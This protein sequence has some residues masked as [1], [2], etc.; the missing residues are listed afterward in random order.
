MKKIVLPFILLLCVFPFMQSYAN[1]ESPYFSAIGMDYDSLM[2]ILKDKEVSFDRKSEL[3]TEIDLVHPLSKVTE[4]YAALLLQA[5]Q[6]ED[7]TMTVK[8]YSSIANNMLMEQD[9]ETAKVYLD[10]AY[11]YEREA[12][13]I[14]SLAMLNFMMGRYYQAVKQEDKAHEYIYKTIDAYEGLAGKR[15]VAIILLYSMADAYYKYSDT[16]SLKKTLDRMIPLT[17]EVNQTPYYVMTYSVAYTYYGLMYDKG[18]EHNARF[19]DSVMVYNKKISDIYAEAD[20]DNKLSV[21]SMVIQSYLNTAEILSR[22]ENPDWKKINQYVEEAGQLFVLPMS[23]SI[24]NEVIYHRLKAKVLLQNGDYA[25]ALEEAEESLEIMETRLPEKDLFQYVEAYSLLAEINEK[26]GD[27]KSALKYVRLMAEATSG[28]NEKQRYEVVKDLEAKYETSQKELEISRLNEEKQ[29]DRY[30]VMMMII[31][32]IVLAVLFAIAL[33]YSRMQRLKKEKEAALMAKQMEEKEANYQSLMK[34]AE[35]KQMHQYLKGLET[36]RARLAK[37]LH[38]NVSNG[39]VTL[40]MQIENKKDIEGITG[41]LG[42]LHEKVRSISHDLMPPVF[43]YAS[44]PEVLDDY[45]RTL[46]EASG[47]RFSLEINDNDSARKVSHELALEIYRMVQ[48]TCGNILKHACAANA[49]V[50]L[51]FDTENIILAIEDDGQGFDTAA[52]KTGIGLQ[53]ISDRAQSLG[54]KFDIESQPGKGCRMVVTIPR[55]QYA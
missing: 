35:I 5:K 22:T 31:I 8:L 3:V 9:F 46:N 48:E 14:S 33:L 51:N 28:I 10:S 42:D 38:D 26:R 17:R 32:F 23:G 45:V 30:R 24:D 40:K 50:S 44:L 1:E 11:L 4:V 2:T 27:Y 20:D 19:V 29:D 49:V 36:E 18:G 55:Q 39:L 13:D 47:T 12:I 41:S 43:Q 15:N 53:I 54:G 16:A 52:K 25:A 21:R 7:K 6:Q 37:E 34:E